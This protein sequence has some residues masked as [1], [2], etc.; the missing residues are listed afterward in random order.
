MSESPFPDRGWEEVLEASAFVEERFADWGSAGV[1]QA[2]KLVVI[3]NYFQQRREEWVQLRRSGRPAP[4]D[5]GL[6][7]WHPGE[8]PRLRILRHWK[9]VEHEIRRFASQSV[10]ALAQS[11]ALLSEVQGFRAAIERKLTAEEIIESLRGASDE[12][13]DGSAAAE[14]DNADTRPPL[15]GPALVKGPRRSLLKILLD[16]RSIQLLLAFGGALIVVG[17]V[18]LLWVNEFFTPPRTAVGIGVVNAALLAGGWWV[19]RATRYQMAGRAV[20]LLACL[21]MPL[22]LWYWHANQLVTLDGHLWVAALF[23]SVLYAVSAFSL[24]DELFVYVFTA[25]VTMT[26]LLLLADL[27]PS[28]QRFWEIALP[29][30]LLVVLGLLAI[31]VERAFPAQEGPFSRGRFGLAF[32]WSGHALLGA[33]LLLVLGA[34]ISGH[35]LYE[36]VFKSLYQKWQATPSPMVNELRWL[37]LAL[38]VAGTYAYIYSDLVVRRIGVY[39][40]IAAG[41]LLWAMILAVELLNIVVGIDALIAVLAATSLAVNLSQSALLRDC[42]Y[43]RAL[44]V[45][46]VLLPLVAVGLGVLVYFRAIS[47]DLKS[48]WQVAPP[49]WGYVGAMLL[50]AVSC[51]VG[52]HLYQANR[53]RLG[54]LYFFATTAALLVAATALLAA[55]GL[56]TWQEHAPW[57]MLI[58]IAYVIAARLYRTKPAE[59]PLVQVSHAATAAMLASS[60]ASAL[61]GFAPIQQQ[62]LNL[63]LAVFFAEAAVFYGLATVLHRQAWCIRLG[64]AMACGAVWQVLTYFGVTAEMYTLTFALVG[65]GLLIAYRF[66]GVERFAAGPLADAAFQSANTLLSL[67]FVAAVFLGLSRLATE[68]TEWAFV[69]L[70]AVLTFISLLALALVR[71]HAWRRW[72][73]VTAIGQAALTFLC[74]GVLVDLSPWQKLEVFSVAV[75][76]LLLVVGHV[77]WYREQERQNDMVSLSLFLGSVLVGLPLAVATLID[78]SRDHFIFLNEMGFLAA[79]VVLLTTGLLFQLRA[80]TLCGAMLTGLYFVTLLIFVPWSRMNTIAVSITV[81]GGALFILGLLLSVYRDR[82]LTLPEQVKRREGVFRVLNWR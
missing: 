65:L 12:V 49:A 10:L 33:G 42:R 11:H 66:A 50:T 1:L 52:A 67:S 69:S 14:S 36:P 17:L 31:H 45:V 79:A 74:M 51:R 19:L 16:P 63:I 64:A 30:T 80:T 70:L 59:K 54:A 38:V 35:W 57:L 78:R 28:P 29:A 21:V 73:V 39:V 48:V 75:G 15:T 44:P 41:T 2:D 3:R 71:H 22:N 20:T 27:P 43:T 62:P 26:G 37:A 5:I 8:S 55:V 25:G 46:G 34:Q 24:R 72:Y 60:L 7:E 32:F 81:G 4:R 58:P 53:P 9:Y 13:V 6:P 76:V 61:E 82:L 56:N 47:A 40:H 68:H 23:I 18:I 77:G